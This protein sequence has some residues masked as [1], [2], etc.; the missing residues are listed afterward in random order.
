MMD[1]LYTQRIL[2]LAADISHI[3]HLPSPQAKA[4][5]VSRLCGSRVGVELCFETGGNT[6][7]N[8]GVV[9][10]FAQIVSACALG[11]VSCAIV[12]Q[13]IIGSGADELRQVSAQMRV[14]LKEGGT[15]PS[16]EKWQD[17]KVLAPVHDYPNRHASTLLIFDAIET[18][19]QQLGH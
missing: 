12:A 16:G 14:M 10:E 1:A 5:V 3:G 7:G 6:G 18:C 2:Q 17:L 13:H 4:E 15:P 11:Q 9:S 8:T 19:L